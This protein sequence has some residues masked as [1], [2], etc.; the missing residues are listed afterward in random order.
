MKI[1][2]VE[3]IEHAGK[4]YPVWYRHERDY[5]RYHPQNEEQIIVLGRTAAY[6]ELEEGILAAFSEC[7]VLDYYN[8]HLGRTITAGRLLRALENPDVRDKDGV[9]IGKYRDLMMA[10]DPPKVA[11][12]EA[13]DVHNKIAS[14]EV[15]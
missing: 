13:C 9:L 8:K 12:L 6:V 14:A 10:R 11:L 7:S 4:K 15:V 2:T 3:E 1:K 5:K